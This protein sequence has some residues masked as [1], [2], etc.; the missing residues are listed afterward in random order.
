MSIHCRDCFFSKVSTVHSHTKEG[1][2]IYHL[3][4]EAKV[5]HR[6]RCKKGKWKT[7]GGSEK[8]KSLMVIRYLKMESCL[9]Y[10]PMDQE[11]REAHRQSLP[12][13]QLEYEEVW[14]R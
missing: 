14:R 4:K 11:D 7:V 9:D 10:Q 2:P 5:T 8:L 6:V 13:T 3:D 12:E 1:I